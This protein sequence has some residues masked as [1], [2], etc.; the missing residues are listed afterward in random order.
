MA[1][2]LAIEFREI[3]AQTIAKNG[4]DL[5]ALIE[6]HRSGKLHWSVHGKERIGDDFESRSRSGD[7]LFRAAGGHPG[8]LHL[9]QRGNLG[10]STESKSERVEVADETATRRAVMRII[11]KNF[12]HDQSQTAVTAEHIERRSF[13]GRDEGTGWVIGMDENHGSRPDGG[14][15]VERIE[16]DLPTM[17]VEQW[18]RNEFNVGEIGQKLE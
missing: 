12:V 1:C 4:L 13:R 8:K 7:H 17:I 6:Q 14:C 18:I 5:F 2:N 3:H 16:I 15:L 11:E 9:R 10:H